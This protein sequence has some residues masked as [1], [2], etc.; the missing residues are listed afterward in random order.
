VKE[1]GII[2]STGAEHQVDPIIYGTGFRVTDLLGPVRFVGCNGVNLSDVWQD[3]PEAYLGIAAA[4]FPNLFMLL[5]PNTGL[6]RNS[7]VFMAEQQIGYVMQCLRTMHAHKISAMEVR[8]EVQTRFNQ[9][10]Q[11]RLQST[12]RVSGC[13]SWYQNASGKNVALWP[14]FTFEY[15]NRMRKARFDDYRFTKRDNKNA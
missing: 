15:W 9:H 6:G 2:T 8:A 4:G 10:I 12:V 5:G 13:R 14:G 7:V 11:H 3:A 1:R